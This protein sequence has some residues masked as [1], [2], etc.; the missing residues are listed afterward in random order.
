MDE[1]GRRMS[2]RIVLGALVAALAFVAL[3]AAAPD[4]GAKSRQDARTEANDFIDWCFK[5][6]GD[7]LVIDGTGDDF[8][9]VCAD[10]G[11]GDFVC[12]WAGS[13]G[14]SQ[15]CF[16]KA[17]TRPGGDLG[18]LPVFGP[19]PAAGWHVTADDLAADGW[20]ATEPPQQSDK[21]RPKNGKRGKGGKG[22][23]R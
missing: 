6:G 5:E 12:G 2:S 16:L 11:S 23:R 20:Q 14:Y 3:A 17:V 18:D 13:D 4:A 10:L 19:D 15:D 1:N 9:V 22:G 21:S 7:P 8:L